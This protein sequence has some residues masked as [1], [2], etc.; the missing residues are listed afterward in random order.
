MA[1][2]PAA[3]MARYLGAP[4]P[5]H[6]DKAACVL[7]WDGTRLDQGALQLLLNCGEPRVALHALRSSRG[8]ARGTQRQR[9]AAAGGATP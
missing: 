8:A 2:Y 3:S 9:A 6:P 4:P 1:R 7:L 5:A